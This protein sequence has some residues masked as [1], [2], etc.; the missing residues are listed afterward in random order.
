MNVCEKV[1]SILCVLL[2]G[3]CGDSLIHVDDKGKGP[4]DPPSIDCDLHEHEPNSTFGEAN[5][6]GTLPI[7]GENTLCGEFTNISVD[8]TDRDFL[9]L[10]L[11][12]PPKS[13]EV[14][15][16]FIVETDALVFPSIRLWQTV[17][18]KFGTPTGQYSLLGVFYGNNGI[19]FVPDFSIPYSFLD[20]NDLF[21]QIEASS[22]LISSSHE[23]TL[24]Y[25]TH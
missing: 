16:T 15:V 22:T 21:V 25:F 14:Y 4:P 10:F 20:N 9:Y 11:N 23:Y 2:A 7:L 13:E 12:P 3:S 17:Y 5:F 18:D 8:I 1:C 24:E 6:V 19:L